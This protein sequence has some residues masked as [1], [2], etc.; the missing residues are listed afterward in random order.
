MDS[1]LMGVLA[2]IAAVLVVA[3]VAKFRSRNVPRSVAE[4]AE[5]LSKRRARMLPALAVIF[6][7]QQVTFFSQLSAPGPHSAEKVKI[8]AWLVLSIVLLLALAT[9]GFWLEPREVRDLIDDENTQA[10]RRDA[11]QWGF[12]FAMASAILVYVLAMFET[13]TARDAVHLV[14]SFGIAAALIRWGVLERRAHRGA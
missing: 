3:A 8:A 14:M 6:L 11:M 1:Y 12:L 4:K 10:N 5:F 13:L 7:S 2:G 9:K